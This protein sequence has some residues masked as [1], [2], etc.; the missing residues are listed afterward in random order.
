MPSS[1]ANAIILNKILGGTVDF[2]PCGEYKRSNAPVL[3]PGSSGCN[4]TAKPVVLQSKICYN[5]YGLIWS[6]AYLN[7]TRRRGLSGSLFLLCKEKSAS[8]RM[9]ITGLFCYSPNFYNTKCKDGREGWEV[10]V[11]QRI[12]EWREKRNIKQALLRYSLSVL[13]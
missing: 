4:L 3:F 5:F 12:Y 11:Q 8:F 13:N 6:L 9:P 7:Y 2:L 10:A 1:M